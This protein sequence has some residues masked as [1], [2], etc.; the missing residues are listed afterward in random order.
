[1]SCC[2]AEAP[3]PGK[4]G[5]SEDAHRMAVVFSALSNPARIEILQ[6][7][8]RH[9]HCKCKEITDVLPLAQSTV[10]QHL[11]V[12][13]EAELIRCE[14]K[15]PSSHYQVNDELLQDVARTTGN[16][17]NACCKSACC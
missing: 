3:L 11:K 15:P 14:I 12:L 4:A 6:H 17:M 16:F 9:R 10:S 7:I 13:V 1:M 8:A 5:P 2:D